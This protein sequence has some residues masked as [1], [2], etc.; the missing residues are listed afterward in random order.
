MR[1]KL[2]RLAVILGSL[3]LAWGLLTNPIGTL[4]EVVPVLVVL[5]VLMLITQG[6]QKDASHPPKGSE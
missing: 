1:S 3:V 4:S 6:R 5:G 2:T